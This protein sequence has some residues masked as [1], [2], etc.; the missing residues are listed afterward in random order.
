[1]GFRADLEFG[2]AY[3]QK[4]LDLIQYDTYTIAKGKFKP[5]DVQITHDSDTITFE[6]KSDRKAQQSGNM[7]IEFE[8][9]NKPS[10][11]TS[12]EADYWVYF[13]DGTTDYYLIP[14]AEIREAIVK[15]QYKRIVRGGDGWRAKMYLF[16]LT[17]FTD[18]LDKY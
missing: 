5:W 15:Q 16:P 7:V 8:C 18:F 4:L 1:M 13:V 9:N 11:I 17:T 6:V 12:T 10:G 3:Q 2:E 14:T